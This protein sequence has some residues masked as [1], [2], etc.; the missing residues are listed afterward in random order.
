MMACPQ[1]NWLIKNIQQKI[2]KDDVVTKLQKSKD[3]EKLYPN[4]DPD[5]NNTQKPRLF[6]DMSFAVAAIVKKI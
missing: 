4:C 3:I 6:S 2:L 1:I 5:R